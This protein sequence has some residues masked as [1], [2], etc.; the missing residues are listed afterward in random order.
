[1]A[2]TVFD[3]DGGPPSP[4][5]GGTRRLGDV[6]KDVTFDSS[7][8]TGGEPLVAADLGLTSILRLIASPAAGYV[9]SYDHTNGKLIAYRGGAT[10]AVL[11]E[12]SNATNMA[13]IKTRV[14]ARGAY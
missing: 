5:V 6:I 7:Y 1:M 2:V 4:V 8:P 10:G 11:A 9:F 12:E 14:L 3:A 13:T